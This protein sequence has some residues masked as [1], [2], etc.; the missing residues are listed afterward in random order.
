MPYTTCY[1][2]PCPSCAC[3]E[4]PGSWICSRTLRIT[5]WVEVAS[6]SEDWEIWIWG[7][8]VFNNHGSST[9]HV[10]DS[11]Y[12]Y[13]GWGYNMFLTDQK[14]CQAAP[15]ATSSLWPN[16]ATGL[17]SPASGGA[18]KWELDFVCHQS[19]WVSLYLYNYKLTKYP[20]TTVC[21]PWM[22]IDRSMITY[23]YGFP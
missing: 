9:W 8:G 22:N 6:E 12:K 7:C 15:A 16:K 4:H 17:E 18:R 2:Q 13:V 10:W 1:Q 14:S 11:I 5:L 3:V 20:A 19:T 23:P 21:K